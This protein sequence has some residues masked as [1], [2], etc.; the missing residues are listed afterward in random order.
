MYSVLHIEDDADIL[1][2]AQMGLSLDGEITLCQASNGIK[3]IEKAA[4]LSPDLI[5]LDYL[6]PGLSGP[7]TFAKLREIEE[8]SDTPIAF[9]TARTTKKDE[10]QM[11]SLGAVAVLQKPFDPLALADFVRKHA[12][13]PAEAVL[14]PALTAR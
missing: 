13:K 11:K 5:L 3:G 8:I 14:P 4:S 9:V 1:E 7:D 12:R 10:D 6:M 2:L